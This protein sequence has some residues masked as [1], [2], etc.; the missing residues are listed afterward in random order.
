MPSS[1][2][3]ISGLA[4]GLT[5]AGLA[6]PAAGAPPPA[7]AHQSPA[8]S[9]RHGA[10]ALKSALSAKPITVNAASVDVDYKTHTVLY[11]QVV[12]SQ[13]NIVVRA[14]RARTTMGQDQRNSRWTLQGNVRIQAPPRGSLSA[15]RAVVSVLG[16]RITRATVSGN[17]AQFTQQSRAGKSARGHAEQIVYDLDKGTVQLSGNAWLSD[18]RNQMSAPV[19]TYDVLKDRIMGR[20]LGN[21]GRVHIT[22]RPQRPRSGKKAL[23]GKLPPATRPPKPIALEGRQGAAD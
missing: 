12:I 9:A 10:G 14:D 8:P 7:R 1:P 20:S 13:G 2:L 5:L 11:R 6:S 3:L 21:G 17:P 22:I 23:E 19:L 18:G 16:S 4:L 15:D